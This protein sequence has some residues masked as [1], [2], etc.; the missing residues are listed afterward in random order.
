MKKLTT[1]LGVA[2]IPMH[3]SNVFGTGKNYA[4]LDED[5]LQLIEKGLETA[6][7]ADPAVVEGLKNDLSAA[8]AAESSMHDAVS[9]AL[10]LN[11]LEIAEGQSAVEA[12]AL[13][14]QTCKEYGA[15]KERG[16]T[17]PE[18]DG[19]EKPDNTTDPSA[20]FAHN[21]IYDESKY[22]TLK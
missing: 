7:G 9:V 18:N 17:K 5:Q 21:K 20:N 4:K 3:N 19:K 8:Q 22:T 1:L 11:G 10:K 2:T 13:L 6:E 12:I 16:H 15:S 14:A